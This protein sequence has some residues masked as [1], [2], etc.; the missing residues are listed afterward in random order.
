MRQALL[1]PISFMVAA[2]LGVEAIDCAVAHDSGIPDAP[3]TSMEAL[4]PSD[5]DS[6]GNTL[7]LLQERG[8]ISTAGAIG[9]HPASPPQVEV[10]APLSTY[11]VHTGTIDYVAAGAA[12]RN[13][14]Y[15]L[16]A[17]D[18]VGPPVAAY[19]V[20]SFM[21]DVPNVNGVF[22]GHAIIGTVVASS[23]ENPCW[24]STIHTLVANVTDY[25][26]KGANTLMA[27]PSGITTG[28][29]PWGSPYVLPMLE[30]ATLIVVFDSGGP[31]REISLYLAANTIKG[32]TTLRDALP[33]SFSRS[34]SAKT[35][36]IVSDGQLHG[37]NAEWNYAII[38]SDTFY[39][40]DPKATT[41]VWSYGNLWDTS[42]Y[43]VLV[44][45][46]STRENAGLV[47]NGTGDCLS[48]NGQVL[49]VDLSPMNQPPMLFWTGEVNYG[50]DGLDPEA[51]TTAATFRYRVAYADNEG[52]LPSWVEV[53][54]EKPLGVIWGRFAADRVGWLGSPDDFVAGAIFAFNATLPTGTDFWY[55]FNSSDG[56]NWATGPPT[57]PIDAPDVVVDGPPVAV[58]QASPSVAHMGD[59]I[60]F[61]GSG[62]ID[63]FGIT[64]YLWDFG[65]GASDLNSVTTH[66][67][68]TRGTFTANLT[69]WD[70]AN[71]ND[72]DASLISIEN[73][74]PIACAGPDRG[75]L[76]NN[77]VMLDGTGSIDPDGD[78][79]T[80]SWNQDTGPSVALVGENTAKP[81]FTPANVGTFSFRVH[82][83]DGFGGTSEDTVT[84]TI[85]GL[86]PVAELIATPQV[87]RVGEKIAFDGSGSSDSDGVIVQ[88]RFE[89]DDGGVNLGAD[90]TCNHSYT[91]PGLYTVTLTVT[92]DDGNSSS[93]TAIVEIVAPSVSVSVNYKPLVA[94]VF[95]ILLAVV[96][97]WSSK[98][99]PW[100]GGK[101]NPAVMKAFLIVS[102]PFVSA[103]VATGVVSLFR[104]ELSIP[105]IIGLGTIID[106]AILAIGMAV[107]I[108]R[109]QK[110]RQ[111]R[112]KRRGSPENR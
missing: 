51:G 21:D 43:S 73:R 17:L 71:Q 36:Y 79:L 70:A 18:W 93:A 15:G 49:R 63:D 7:S 99:K 16:I 107:A 92:D 11:A 88:F 44:P 19:L 6:A 111:Q 100:K 52:D 13:Q 47:N 30:G 20:W 64:T 3:S 5:D 37:H 61:D 110:G 4:V 59:E 65:D 90:A 76:K 55:F 91:T 109:L 31:E 112:E 80:Y 8:A 26:V 69:V 103:E 24:Y 68:S 25:V 89:F 53:C 54:I 60:A 38:D 106:G 40:A 2:F 23:P 104:G 39:G 42:T 86:P 72:T 84:V 94:A 66:A 41:T 102:M 85:W 45:I 10:N 56:G 22:N 12:M 83:D 34:P 82:V 101:E 97:T 57:N 78:M 33:H 105:P 108:I 27:F 48:W 74:Q 14:G 32:F 77:L 81:T 96:G 75:A 58:A 87:A 9:P 62:S 28:D 95:G 1:V 46:G 67:Y 50:T 35:T 29:D 98:R